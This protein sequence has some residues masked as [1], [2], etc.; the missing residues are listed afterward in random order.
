MDANTLKQVRIKTGALKRNVKDIEF[1]EKELAKEQERLAGFE[2]ANDEDK[3]RQQKKVL[4]ETN[5]MIP[6]GIQRLKASFEEVSQLS[7]ELP[8]APEAPPV[9]AAAASDDEEIKKK[10]QQDEENFKKDQE[11]RESIKESLEVAKAALKARGI[12]VEEATAGSKEVAG[13]DDDY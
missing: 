4:D 6:L 1:A 3:V 2:A 10:Q 12:E 9:A 8:P 11:A 13:A 5:K 7:T